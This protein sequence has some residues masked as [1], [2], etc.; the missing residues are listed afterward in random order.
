[1]STL[2][3]PA[4]RPQPRRDVPPSLR[5]EPLRE[6]SAPPEACAPGDPPRRGGAVLFEVRLRSSMSGS[7]LELLRR[8]LDMT[9]QVD[10]KL[11]VDPSSA[12]HAPLD[13]STSLL[14]EAGAVEDEWILRARTWAHPSAR[15]VHD[16]QV[17][18]AQVAHLLDPGVAIP[19]RMPVE[20]SGPPQRPV[21]R[22]ANRRLAASRRRL[23]GLPS[24]RA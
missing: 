5:S 13:Q 16:W 9:T 4:W 15:T 20:P 6:P 22:V 11:P 18:V 2:T 1:M 14:L 19:D 24:D 21:G 8:R 10:H 12:G 23:V 3:V 7:D 17:R